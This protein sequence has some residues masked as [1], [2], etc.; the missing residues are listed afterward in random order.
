MWLGL[1]AG[2]MDVLYP[3]S[4]GTEPRIVSPVSPTNFA[5][6][7]CPIGWQCGCL[8]P[9]HLAFMNLTPI[10]LAPQSL[11]QSYPLLL[12][13]QHSNLDRNRSVRWAVMTFCCRALHPK[14]VYDGSFIIC[15][16]FD[17]LQSD[18]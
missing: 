3:C 14:L 15:F 9:N 12:Y 18:R 10:R 2:A 6:A 11:R 17:N 8:S 13:V 1:V 16:K 7:D 5:A 4:I